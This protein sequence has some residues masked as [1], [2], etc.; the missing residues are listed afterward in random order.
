MIF[1]RL[2]SWAAMDIATV[3][4][5][6]AERLARV[7]SFIS[8]QIILGVLGNSVFDRQIWFELIPI[9]FH[10]DSRM[11][12]GYR[13]TLLQQKRPD[14]ISIDRE[15]VALHPTTMGLRRDQAN[16]QFMHAMRANG[17]TVFFSLI[18]NFQ[19]ARDT[20]TV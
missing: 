18:R 1:G 12:W 17:Y 10:P 8:I 6:K 2:R 19:P 13:Q 16:V 4:K 5:I 14:R 15:T 11:I 7:G 3:K 9:E 20:E